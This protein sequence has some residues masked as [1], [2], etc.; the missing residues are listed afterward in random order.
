MTGCSATYSSN[1]NKKEFRLF[2]C[3]IDTK[4]RKRWLINCRRDKWT[5]TNVKNV[6]LVLQS[7]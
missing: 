5:P 1:S 7:D 2:R 6:R 4:R 3:P